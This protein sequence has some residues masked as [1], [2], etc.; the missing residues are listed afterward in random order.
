MRLK[1]ISAPV[2]GDML[3]CVVG[4]IHGLLLCF[5]SF[6]ALPIVV[7]PRDV[8]VSGSPFGALGRLLLFDSRWLIPHLYLLSMFNITEV[9]AR[10]TSLL[11]AHIEGANKCLVH[12]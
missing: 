10:P 6:V 11:A 1:A 9:R 3:F 4:R 8:K 2:L 5:L 12:S 7:F